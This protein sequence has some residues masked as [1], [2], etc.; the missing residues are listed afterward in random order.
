MDYKAALLQATQALSALQ[1]VDDILDADSYYRY[2]SER[3][4]VDNAEE[5]LKEVI[6]ILARN[7]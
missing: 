2:S 4:A 6:R 3:T 1:A 5:A 7:L